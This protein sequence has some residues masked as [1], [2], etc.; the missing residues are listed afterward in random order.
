MIESGIPSTAKYL[1]KDDCQMAKDC[2]FVH[3]SKDRSTSPR[4]KAKSKA[5]LSEKE[6]GTIA[7]LNNWQNHRLEDRSRKVQAS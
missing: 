3:K 4:R 6:A 1:K 2:P 5:K 7:V